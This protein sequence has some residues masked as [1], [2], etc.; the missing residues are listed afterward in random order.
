MPNQPHDRYAYLE[1]L[2]QPELVQRCKQALRGGRGAFAR[3]DDLRRQLNRMTILLY[4]REEQLREQ[5]GGA[6]GPVRSMPMATITGEMAAAM[7][8]V[9]RKQQSDAQC[10]VCMEALNGSVDQPPLKMVVCPTTK[11]AMCMKCV[12]RWSENRRLDSTRSESILNTLPE[13]K[14]QAWTNVQTDAADYQLPDASG[15]PDNLEMQCP[16]C[17]I[18]MC[19]R[20]VYKHYHAVDPEPEVE[21]KLT[22]DIDVGSLGSADRQKAAGSLIIKH[23]SELER[24]IRYNDQQQP[25]VVNVRGKGTFATKD[26]WRKFGTFNFQ[27]KQWEIPVN[28]MT[29]GCLKEWLLCRIDNQALAEACEGFELTTDMIMPTALTSAPE[30]PATADAS[31]QMGGGAETQTMSVREVRERAIDAINQ[32]FPDPDTPVRAPKRPRTKQ[33]VPDP[34]AGI[35]PRSKIELPAPKRLVLPISHKSP[36]YS[37]DEEDQVPTTPPRSRGLSIEDYPF[38]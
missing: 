37:S 9:L 15:Y 10:I 4:Q 21:F 31:T 18:P 35:A 16:I 2:S 27:L 14:R 28:T 33:T 12:H 8:D 17:K 34:S 5:Q 20:G 30:P 3:A 38:H 13:D 6:A 25:T 24:S 36:L 19:N 1:N 7:C 11:H 22:M 26:V 29:D 23:L 32:M